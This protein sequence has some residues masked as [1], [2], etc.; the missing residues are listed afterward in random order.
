M[1]QIQEFKSSINVVYMPL[2]YLRQL[3]SGIITLG[4]PFTCYRS[5]TYDNYFLFVLKKC[6][7]MSIYLKKNHPNMTAHFYCRNSLY[8]SAERMIFL[9]E[10]GYYFIRSLKIK[11]K[12]KNIISPLLKACTS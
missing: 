7:K 11:F 6:P 4:F 9:K 12:N 8:P 2:E 1:S 5:I 3:A 10:H